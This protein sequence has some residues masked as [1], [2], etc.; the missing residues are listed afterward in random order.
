MQVVKFTR[1]GSHTG[2]RRKA[3]ALV[4]V[5]VLLAAVL[6]VGAA[7]SKGVKISATSGILIDAYSGRVLFEKNAYQRLSM[8]STTKIITA[9]TAIENSDLSEVVTVS[10]KAAEVE[11]SSMWLAEGE[12]I[13]IENLLYG[14]MLN[15]GN[16]AAIAIAEH[17]SGSEEEFAK[18]M[19]QLA[20]KIGTQNTNFENPHGLD[21]KEHY[22]TSRDLAMITRYAMQNRK[23]AEIVA[24]KTKTVPNEAAE[25]DRTLTN[26]NKLLFM[27]EGAN[28][29]KT[30]YTKKTG[31]CLVSS[32]ERD[33]IKLI[34][35]TINAPD[36]WNDHR[37]MLDYGFTAYELMTPVRGGE[38]VGT[39]A[40]EG[41]EVQ[42]AE[43]Y[44]AEDINVLVRKGGGDK[45]N[46]D[47]LVAEIT[48]APVSANQILGEAVLYINGIEISR[49]P[50]ICGTDI[51]KKVL[52]SNGPSSEICKKSFADNIIFILSLM[53]SCM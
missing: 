10:K 9:I 38:S 46:I 26:H 29:V 24:S 16:D 11:G 20:A 18:L 21:S 6:R 12:K 34:A 47:V 3:Y 36:D 5:F 45:I 37:N 32:A 30:G 14:L 8:A 52:F 48:A 31:R 19:N 17:I 49:N 44:S 39:A 2:Y 4:C 50:L 7:D 33:G 28:G 22:T 41:A 40:I 43:I 13:T 1:S 51:E 42:V 27:Y 35:V 15:S 23:F 25:W 53:F